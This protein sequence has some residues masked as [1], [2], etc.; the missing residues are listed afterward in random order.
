VWRPSRYIRLMPDT[1]RSSADMLR[2]LLVSATSSTIYLSSD[3]DRDQNPRRAVFDDLVTT[4][5]QALDGD[6]VLYATHSFEDAF[7]K[8]NEPLRGSVH[9]I[10]STLLLSAQIVD[11]QSFNL[12]IRPLHTISA[13]TVSSSTPE[14]T[15]FVGHAMWSTRKVTIDLD[16]TSVTLPAARS[17]SENAAAFAAFYPTLIAAL[18]AA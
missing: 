8:M 15:Y 13:V 4:L 17:T 7:R 11:W 18:R 12:T 14:A 2:E 3:R 16:G 5:D 6:V 10:T 9:A 1:D